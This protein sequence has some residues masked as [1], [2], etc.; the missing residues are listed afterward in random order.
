MK[1][2]TQT[3]MNKLFQAMIL[4]TFTVKH[5]TDYEP[6]ALCVES[7]LQYSAH[8]QTQRNTQMAK[9]CFMFL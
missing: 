7:H 1:T 4:V 8:T 9:T 6:F 2:I 3:C 5:E